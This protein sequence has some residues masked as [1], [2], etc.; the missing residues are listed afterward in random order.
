MKLISGPTQPAARCAVAFPRP[1]ILPVLLLPLL[2]FHAGAQAAEVG[3]AGYTNDFSVQPVAADWATWSRAGNANDNYGPD[4]DV[5]SII[6]AAGVVSQTAVGAAS[7]AIQLTNATWSSPGQ[8]LQTRPTGNR[9]TTLMAKFVNN[10]GTNASEIAIG[11]LTAMLGAAV[12]EDAGLGERVYFSMSGALNSWTNLPTFT[13]ASTNLS[14]I[15]STNLAINWTNGGS[16][17]LLWI[18]DNASGTTADMAY[19]IDNFSL[20]VTAGLPPVLAAFVNTPASNSLHVSTAPVTATATAVYGT[21]PYSIEYFTNSGVGNTV[22]ASAGSSAGAPFDVPLGNLAAGT[23]NIFAVVTDGQPASAV[24][25]TNTFLVAD[26]I[27]FTLDA[28][29]NGADFDEAVSITASASVAGGTAPYS[30]QFLLDNVP[31][32]SPVTGAPYE[33]NFGPLFVG[34][35][36]VKAVVTDAKGWVS[37]SAVS[38]IHITGALGVTATPTNGATFSFG[39]NI[40]LTAA[41]GGGTAPYSV[42][43]YTNDVLVGTMPSAPFT[44]NLGILEPGIYTTHALVT[45]N[46]APSPHQAASG[47]NTFTVLPNPIVVMVTNPTNG[48]T[49]VAGLPFVFAASAAVGAPLTVARVEFFLNDLPVGLDSAAPFTATV[50]AP[51]AGTQLVYAVATDSLGRTG[52]SATNTV[53]FIIDPLANN[54]FVNRIELGTPA[55]VTGNNTGA[56]TE[57][58]E[59]TTQFGG[60]TFLQWGAT[61]WYK[62]TAPFS[63]SVT[64]DTLGGELDTVLCVYTGTAVNGLTLVQRNND[65]GGTQ[66]SRVSFAVA[67]G[68]EYQIQV[69]GWRPFGQGTVA[70]TGAFQLNLAMPPSVTITSPAPGTVFLAGSNFTVEA[71]AAT[72]VGTI[73]NVALYR[74]G[75]LVG[76]LAGPPYSWVVNNAPAGSN[77][78][79]A[80]ATDNLGQVS[81]SA[82]VTV[83]VFNPGLTLTA[84][85][86]NAT[87]LTANPITLGAYALLDAGTMTNVEF[88][89]N[90]V[91]VGEATNT[92]FTALWMNP[93][94][95]SHRVHA[96]GRADDGATHIS[97]LTFIGVGHPLVASNSVW[98]FRDDG[99]DQGTNWIA[100]DA[101]VSGWGSGPAPLG[102]SDSNGRQVLTTNS[103]GPDANGKY[104]TTYYRQVFNASGLAA[105]TN[106]ILNVQRDDGVVIHLNGAELTRYNMPA[107]PV[108]YT[109]FASANAADDGGATISMNLNPALL[110]E[111]T[112]VVAVELHQDSANS[113]DIW[114]VMEVIGVPAII[115]NLPP[116]VSLIEPTNG[117]FVGPATLQLSATATDSDGTM[118]RVDFYDN[119][120]KI[121][122][123]SGTGPAYAFTWTNPPVGTHSLTAVGVD[124]LGGRGFSA[125]LTNTIYDGEGRPFA[126]VTWPAYGARIQGPT[127]LLVTA[128]ATALDAVTNAE[129]YVNG[130]FF[131]SDSEAPFA[132]WWTTDFGTNELVVVAEG[133]N[134]LRGTSA[135]SIAVITMPPT[136]T[137]APFIIAKSPPPFT[138]VT[139]MTSITVVFSEPVQGVDAGDMLINGVPATGLIGVAGMS[140]YTFTFPEPPY[141]EVEVVFAAGHGITD[142]GWPTLL[143]LDELDPAAAWEYEQ[144]D[145]V[146]PVLASRSPEPGV[147]VSNLFT[148]SV[149][150]SEAVTGVNPED[151][152]VSGTPAYAVTN[153]DNTNFVFSVSQP[154]SGTVTVSWAASPGIVDL[155]SNAFVPEGWS[156]VLD[157]RTLIFGSNTVWRWRPATN[158]AST[159]SNL[160]RF[161]TGF[162]D[163]DWS[164]APAPF[165][166][167]DPYTNVAL[168]IF[169]TRLTGMRSNYTCIF[170]RKEFVISTVSPVQG[171]S[172][173][174]Q[175]DDGFI[176]WINGVEV[177]RVNVPAGNPAYNSRALAAV[178]ESPGGG[179]PY[180]L[181]TLSNFWAAVNGTNVLA[182][183]AFNLN[184][185][186]ADF[187]FNAQLSGVYSDT[188]T[189]AP[190]VRSNTPPSG[191]VFHLTNLVV[192]FSE[193][194]TN[195]DAADLL[196]NGVPASAVTTANDV[197]WDFTFPQ[198]PYGPV[199][200]TWSNAHG[201]VDFDTPAR[202]FNALATNATFRYLLVNPSAPVIVSKLPAAS[203]TVTSL[204]SVEITFSEPVTGVD[205]ADLRLNGVAATGLSTVSA[206]N[207]VFTFSQP[208]YG[209]VAVTWAAGHGIADVEPET[210]AFD[211]SRPGHT[212]SYPLVNPVPSVAIT[213][214]TNFSYIV[215]GTVVT[216]RATAT[217]NDGVI[218]RVGFYAGADLLGETT[219]APYTFG[220]S[221][222]PV[223]GY[224]LRAV[225]V[226][227]TGIY[228]TSAP[229]VLN[230]VSNPPVVLT[231]GPYLQMMSSTGTVVRWR[232][233]AASDA[234]VRYGPAPDSL[235]NVAVQAFS[236]NEHIVSVP[237]LAPETFYYYSI[238]SS[239]QLLAGGGIAGS[240]HWFK[241]SPVT[242]TRGPTRIWALGDSGTANANQ[243]AVRDAFYNFAAST[244]GPMSDLW[245]MLG[246][247]AYNSGTDTE[248]QNAVFNIYPATLRNYC[249]WPTIGNHETAQSTSTT[250]TYPYLDIFSLPQNGEAGGVP[251]GSPKYYSFDYANIHFICLDSMTSGR[252]ASTPMAQWLTND[253]ANNVQEWTVVFFHH[254]PYTKGSHDS[255]AESDLVAIRQNLMPLL[256]AGHVD[257]VLCGHSH[258]YERSYLLNGHYGLSGTLTA[259]MKINGGN[260]RVDGTGAYSKNPQGEGVVYSV[261][262]SSGQISGGALNHPAHFIGINELGSLVIDVVSNRLDMIF[263]NSAGQ[264]RD[265]VT[266]I[267]LVPAAPTGLAATGVSSTQIDLAW[268]D[269]ATNELSFVIERS[270]DGTNFTFALSVPANSTNASDTGLLPATGYYHRVRAVN[271]VGSSDWSNI[272]ASSTTNGAPVIAAISDAIVSAGG[273][274]I[275]T[276]TAVDPDAGSQFVWALDPGF[277]A[278]ARL[279]PTN[280]VFIWLP[281]GE[282]AGTTNSITVRVTDNGV[283]PL[284]AT[285]TFTVIVRDLVELG[286]GSQA[287]RAGQWTNVP[288]TVFSTAPLTNLGVSVQFQIERLAG[289]AAENVAPALGTITLDTNIAGT[290]VVAFNSLPGQVLSGT[291]TLARLHFSA[292]AGQSSAFVPLHLAGPVVMRAEEGLAPTVVLKDGRVV[293]IAERGLLE[294]GAG[295]NDTRLLTLY[296]IPGVTYTIETSP[297]PAIPASWSFWQTYTPT[298]LEAV[299]VLPPPPG[300]SIFYRAQH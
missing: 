98:H 134:G 147:T 206:S 292:V 251:S 71:T 40:V 261:A 31:S 286:V 83:A 119:G 106:V 195:V 220:W 269:V 111:G 124:D 295:T 242:G 166:Y 140:N 9:Y 271:A 203:T 172:L 84:P 43:F 234:V 300:P 287:V 78:L 63:G 157:A 52:Y 90:D 104:P 62:W 53:V 15:L 284:S 25:F 227:N 213:S 141:G 186:D 153:L 270:L 231:R 58:Q 216:I 87:F 7:P 150:F 102:Y 2:L 21:P 162:P 130:T 201:I 265:R 224:T 82:V 205:A 233:D 61:L 248:Y 239:E 23:Y 36:T 44:T 151:L 262:G 183:Q 105:L 281:S 198:P 192:T 208:P 30:V 138:G 26:P 49:G 173:H 20:R 210:N 235:T 154:L 56:T 14:G 156:F 277:P 114:F 88:F 236:T 117:V 226:D 75:A 177:L 189:V 123:V 250:I 142:Y 135:V 13:S 57:P 16:L 241:T 222:M 176:A 190:Q 38:T 238:G 264:T 168:G 103:F 137:V 120:T 148:V 191:D 12:P 276:N 95:G 159:P 230:I 10:T 228:A 85:L 33:R 144:L 215:A 45:D 149:G 274:L 64:I 232:T 175:S 32:G 212:W 257:L 97:Q 219:N 240:N 93:A 268:N 122:E 41:P 24:S 77:A 115:R 256:E 8:Y 116:A 298:N 108:T 296:G 66:G 89:V 267:K 273:V 275:F 158:E 91:K 60:G 128:F 68:T 181:Y 131:G 199:T 244:N 180:N 65:F 246:D 282:Q 253:L 171:L 170:L 94:G 109:T 17:Y 59:P 50:P 263:L 218:E 126:R 185:N 42:A 136:N 27:A 37:N 202:P 249:L 69:G 118:T 70:Q 29:A 299:L 188:T 160:W 129:F 96:V 133:A 290:G 229:V 260:G 204:T 19:Q 67:A 35:H 145:R 1:A 46:A 143:P 100:L 178:T 197:A 167:N 11:Y 297:T 223:A 6:S 207:Y 217:D 247:N 22:F 112:N 225:A 237:G 165:F 161:A 5:N 196:I 92:P 283:P 110:V 113:S 278:G 86:D 221:N 291:Q 194:V 127:N 293:V 285:R 252:T 164:N 48:Q 107:G 255:D 34:T 18:D 184:L 163:A 51:L 187:G 81:T 72:A 74:G 28:P 174:A 139:N 280:G 146:P 214:P 47:T 259:A 80:V 152:L 279:N 243:I 169:G 200:V 211:P 179:A 245:L 4:T 288:F 99:S 182:I 254:P 258:S 294:A 101:D 76:E 3:P 121:G 209:N 155:G 55:R 39:E 125:A 193:A 73:T 289:F 54:L 272:A 79:F 132:A 266:L